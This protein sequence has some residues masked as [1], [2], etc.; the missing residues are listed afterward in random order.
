MRVSLRVGGEGGHSD[1]GPLLLLWKA[2]SHIS[3]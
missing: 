2:K 3:E 1:S